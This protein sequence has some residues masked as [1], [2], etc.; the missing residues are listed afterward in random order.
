MIMIIATIGSA[1][2]INLGKGLSILYVLIFWRFILG[3][4]IGGDYPVSSVITSE[5][6]NIKHRGLMISSVF[7]MQGLGMLTGSIIAL[8]F[9]NVLKSSIQH[10]IGKLDF[11]WRIC[12]GFGIMPAMIALYFRIKINESPRYLNLTQNKLKPIGVSG[13]PKLSIEI[14]TGTTQIAAKETK[15]LEDNLDKQNGID[16]WNFLCKWKNLKILFGCSFSWFALDVAFYGSN[17]NQ[18]FVLETIGFSD[19][20]NT[21]DFFEK[22]I[23]GNLIITFCGAC[24]F[25]FFTT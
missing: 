5:F 14:T 3:I 1:F 20:K 13:E 16:L 12:L 9:L 11:L 25:L 22:L 2:S 7:A 8:I 21:F 18:S 10:E 6:A 17:L 24:N 23:L 15:D 4:G 19:D